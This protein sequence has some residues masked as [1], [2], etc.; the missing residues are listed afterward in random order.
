MINVI[1]NAEFYDDET[2]CFGP[3]LEQWDPNKTGMHERFYDRRLAVQIRAYEEWRKRQPLNCDLHVFHTH[4]YG[5]FKPYQITEDVQAEFDAVPWW[6]KGPNLWQRRHQAFRDYCNDEAVMLLCADNVLFDP[7]LDMNNAIKRC[8]SGQTDIISF[9]Q[10]GDVELSGIWVLSTTAQKLF[11]SLSSSCFNN[12]QRNDQFLLHV[13]QL[14]GLKIEIQQGEFETVDV[15][16]EASGKPYDPENH[17][18]IFGGI[19]NYFRW[20]EEEF[21]QWRHSMKW[22]FARTMRS[23]P[24]DYVIAYVQHVTN[25]KMWPAFDYILRNGF[26]EIWRGR[27]NITL[28]TG[29]DKYWVW[30]INCCNHTSKELKKRIFAEDGKDENGRKIKSRDHQPM[31]FT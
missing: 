12:S 22:R 18:L 10:Y 20:S 19:E 25:L 6:P 29:T 24:H 3:S 27:Y 1:F 21:D 15:R 9:Q 31:L 5:H 17:T 8:K 30:G 2:E 23:C 11:A 14:H 7:L 16:L 26:I 13:A 4:F 28:V